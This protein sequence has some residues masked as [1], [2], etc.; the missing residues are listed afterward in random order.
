V[1]KVQEKQAAALDAASRKA[2]AKLGQ[3]TKKLSS[4]EAATPSGAK[5]YQK[6][7]AD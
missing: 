1:E 5:S 4:L 2:A 6:A 7:G 3:A